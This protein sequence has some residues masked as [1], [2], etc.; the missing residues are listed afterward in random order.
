VVE[1]PFGR[2]TASS[3]ALAD[4]L[5]A[6]FPEDQ[7]YRIDHYLGKELT[8]VRR[9]GVEGGREGGGGLG[10]QRAR[11]VVGARRMGGVQGGGKG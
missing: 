11:E 9:G 3:E 8:Q 1:K 10:G 5:G 6:L 2:D 4:Q 7:L